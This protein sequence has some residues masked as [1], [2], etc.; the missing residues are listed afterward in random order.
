MESDFSSVHAEEVDVNFPTD[1]DKKHNII[2]NTTPQLEAL[3]ARYKYSFAYKTFRERVPRMLNELMSCMKE[4][5]DRIMEQCGDYARFALSRV[6]WSLDIL[7]NEVLANEMFK[8]FH[9]KDSDANDWNGFIEKLERREKNQ[10]FSANWLHA[11]CYLYRRISAAF[12]REETLRDYDYFSSQKMCAARN[13]VYLMHTVLKEL[14]QLSRSR[15]S[16]QL[17]LKVSLWGNRYDLSLFKALT[18]KPIGEYDKHLIEDQSADVWR[19]LTEGIHSS[20]SPVTVDIVL[21]NAGF[22]LFTDL[23]LGEYL[24]RTGLVKKVCYHVKAIPWFVSDVTANDFH[25]MLRFLRDHHITE[26]SAF[27]RRLLRLFRNRSMTLCDNSSFWTRPQGCR[28]MRELSPCLYVHLS[29]GAL[30]IFKGD[31]NY[32]K[33]L[34]DINLNPTTP[35]SEGLGDFLPTSICALRVI[36]SDL[37]CGM[38]HCAVEWLTESD[39]NWMLSGEKAVIQLAIKPRP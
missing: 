24:V 14:S 9:D 20:V 11:E 28:F 35:F 32:R 5:E 15:D 26:M 34:D 8:H 25:W 13:I 37:Y 31:L 23:L 1:F 16:F 17:M 18:D 38:P 2:I 7:R 36:K 33:L 29:F 6:L 27:G 22:E 4:K 39:P 3:S 21:D 19:L 12:R 10:W 30:A